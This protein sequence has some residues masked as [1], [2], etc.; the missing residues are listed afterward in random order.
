LLWLLCAALCLPWQLAAAQAGVGR[1]RGQRAAVWLGHTVV[2]LAGLYLLLLLVPGLGFVV[3]IMPVIPL[4]L[5]LLAIPGARVDAVWSV[6]LANAL[7]F[8]WLLALL[9]PLTV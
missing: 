4:V 3:L 7:F 8:G 5:A 2:V 9:F 1:R 6:G